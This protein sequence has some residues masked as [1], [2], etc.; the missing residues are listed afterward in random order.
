MSL[1]EV[2]LQEACLEDKAGCPCTYSCWQL[3]PLSGNCL[4]QLSGLALCIGMSMYLQGTIYG[5]YEPLRWSSNRWKWSQQ[6]FFLMA[7]QND[8]C[9]QLIYNPIQ[10]ETL[11]FGLVAFNSLGEPFHLWTRAHGMYPRQTIRMQKGFK[12]HF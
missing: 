5:G 8:F 2:C 9:L 11:A 1:E 3:I 7:S 4:H 6:T 12:S 10:W